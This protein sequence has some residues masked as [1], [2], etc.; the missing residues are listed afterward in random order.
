MLL[1]SYKAAFYYIKIPVNL[2]ATR[3]LCLSTIDNISHYRRISPQS[4]VLYGYGCF[5][6]SSI[7]TTYCYLMQ[8]IKI[9]GVVTKIK[10]NVKKR[11]DSFG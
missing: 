9:P 1:F 5:I 3:L 7:C 11:I 10:S 6:M 8:S 2:V 4:F